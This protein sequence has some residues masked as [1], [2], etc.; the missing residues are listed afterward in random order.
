MHVARLL[1]NLPCVR[2]CITEARTPA[3][4]YYQI[5]MASASQEHFLLVIGVALVQAVVAGGGGM[6][7]G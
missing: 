6:G 7:G 2:M 1:A 4:A 5:C 3:C